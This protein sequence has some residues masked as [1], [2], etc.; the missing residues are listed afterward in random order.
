M[1]T[2]WA[3][4]LGLF[5]LIIG[6]LAKLVMP[7]KDPGGIWITMLLGI[8]GLLLATWFLQ[9]V[10]SLRGRADRRLDRLIRRCHRVAGNLQ[11]LQAENSI[12]SSSGCSGSCP[13]GSLLGYQSATPFTESDNTPGRTLS[14]HPSEERLVRLTWHMVDTARPEA[15]QGAPWHTTNWS[16]SALQIRGQFR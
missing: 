15:E 12:E 8:A 10:G 4:K 1:A 14:T 16:L 2:F 13:R 5:G 3:A 6:A 11:L 9:S 7:G